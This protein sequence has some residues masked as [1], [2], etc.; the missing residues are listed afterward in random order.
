MKLLVTR[1][2]TEAATQALLYVLPSQ[3]QTGSYKAMQASG[4]TAHSP[5]PPHSAVWQ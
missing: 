5:G 1:R 3:P 4:I 2:M